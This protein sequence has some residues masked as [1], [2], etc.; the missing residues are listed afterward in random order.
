MKCRFCDASALHT[1]VDLVAAPPSN[2]FLSESDLEGPETYLPLKVYVC[3]NCFLVQLDEYKRSD[4]IFTKDYVYLSSTSRTWLEHAK[5]Y[6]EMIIPRLALNGGSSVIEIASNDGYL[7][8]YF[9]E[10]RIPCFGI[11]PATGTAAIAKE[12]GIHVIEEF[13]CSALATTLRG[14]GKSADLIIGNN[15]LAHVPDIN[16]FVAA[17]NIL[18]KPGGTVTMEFPHLMKLIEN[19]QFDTIY[20]E[21]FSYLSF[22]T[23]KAIFSAHGLEIYDVDEIPTHGGSLRIFARHAAYDLPPASGHVEEL[24]ARESKAGVSSI[25]YYR[26]FAQ[27]TLQVKLDLLDFLIRSHREGKIVAAYGAA[28]K[29]NTLLNFCGVKNDLI[30]FVVDAAPTK[31]GRYLPGSHIPVVSEARLRQ[32]KPDYVIV[33]PWNIKDEIVAQL[34]YIREWNGRFV[35][36]IPSLTFA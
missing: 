22:T 9:L 23:V 11:E 34:S 10:R 2:S 6:V 26:T 13:F 32:E 19:C 7:L 27:R 35:F 33:F 31:Q 8:Q 28:A 1:L 21:H 29:G 4:D 24:L 3:E 14:G 36:A 30:S 18:L 5:R 20:H 25:E 17:L 16:D 15:V 12:K